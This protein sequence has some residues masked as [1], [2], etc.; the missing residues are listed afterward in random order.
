M[1]ALSEQLRPRKCSAADELRNIRLGRLG[2]KQPN[3][4]PIQCDFMD[5]WFRLWVC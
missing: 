4:T 3:N 1:R 5:Y 2:L